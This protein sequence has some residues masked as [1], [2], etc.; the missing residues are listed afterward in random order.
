[1]RSRFAKA[2]PQRAMT[3]LHE[4]LDMLRRLENDSERIPALGL[5]AALEGTHGSARRS[6]EAIRE[7]IVLSSL[8]PYFFAGNLYMAVQV[9]NRVGRPDLVAQCDGYCIQHGVSPA[10]FYLEFHDPPVQEARAALGD[11]EYK[12]KRSVG[13]KTPTERF[14]D[15]IVREVDRLLATIPAD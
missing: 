15:M 3:L 4:T 2:D 5:L 7:Q 14:Y 12:R 11:D 13:A 9:F 6:L 10:P 1:M 8:S